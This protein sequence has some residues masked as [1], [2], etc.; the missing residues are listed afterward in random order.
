M[1]R[2]RNRLSFAAFSLAALLGTAASGAAQTPPPAPITAVLT[3]LTIKPDADR[4][5]VPGVMPSEVR[6]TV[7][8]YLNGKIQQWFGRADGRGVM[9][10]FNV[11]TV[12]EAKALMESLPLV[13]AGLATVEYTALTPLGPLRS[14]IAPPPAAPMGDHQ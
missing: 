8:L 2:T 10:I 3:N 7:Q 11:T 9:F 13:K 4:S 14:L 5:K 12:D 1:V 6:E